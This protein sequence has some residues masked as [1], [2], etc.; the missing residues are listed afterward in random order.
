APRP[1][2]GELWYLWLLLKKGSTPRSFNDLL[3]YDGIVHDTFKDT[4][5]A[6]GLLD[7]PLLNEA[8][9]ALQEAV[10]SY[11]SPRHL[12]QLFLLLVRSDFP[13]GVA[14]DTFYT[15]MIDDNWRVY[16]PSPVAQKIKLLQV[17][18]QYL[19]SEGCKT[20]QQLGIAV[21]DGFTLDNTDLERARC[22]QLLN[23]RD[24]DIDIVLDALHMFTEEQRVIFDEI[25][26]AF[27]GSG[28][29]I[30]DIRG[31]AGTGKTILLNAICAQARLD[32]ILTAPSAATGL[33][34]LN[35]EF[36]LTFHRTWDVPVPD[37][38]DDKVLQSNLPSSKRKPL[39]DNVRVCTIDEAPSLHIAA[40][41]AAARIACPSNE[42]PSSIAPSLTNSTAFSGK[43]MVL[44]GDGRQIPPVVP[45][46]GQSET[47]AASIM[48]SSYY[49][50]NVQVRNLTRTM[51]NKED[52]SFSSMVDRIGDGLAL[53]DSDGLVDI[54]G[55]H[56]EVELE[57][58]LDFVFPPN[59]LADPVSCS[60]HCVVTLHNDNVDIINDLVLGRVPGELHTLEGRTLLNHELLECEVDD[61]FAMTG[62]LSTLQHS[63]V[64]SHV[65]NLKVGVCVMLT[66][67]LDVSA[68]LT[69]GAKVIVKAI[70]P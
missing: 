36:G 11:A 55:L 52:P 22:A 37:P 10:E 47:C 14:F 13:V 63:G 26:S 6:A 3:L 18:Q 17:L 32:G 70:L 12:R 64:P 49:R 45:R 25:V 33:A 50:D 38:R 44:A 7:D 1:S 67:N 58:S 20:L 68:G 21:P 24:N 60:K 46:G 5:F 62:Y 31:R 27:R 4:A 8:T 34:A 43:I 48:S 69:N 61:A 56:T 23:N 19:A 51:R 41:E 65:L 30:F 66:R 28:D 40:F 54:P 15:K 9:Y 53:P 16:N 59:I 35:Q 2:E 39:M 42:D 29:A 57:P